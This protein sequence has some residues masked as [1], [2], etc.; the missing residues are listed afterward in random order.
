MVKAE[1]IV[2][3]YGLIDN[4]SVI[5]LYIDNI[6][7]ASQ[8]CYVL[9]KTLPIRVDL[10]IGPVPKDIPDTYIPLKITPPSETD[11]I[12]DL[13]NRTRRWYPA[14]REVA[15][16]YNNKYGPGTEEIK[17]SLQLDSPR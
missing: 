2:F 11:L 4:P 15:L 3:G 8:I 7:A 14:A 5:K 6:Y 13:P 17:A 9:G 12:K 10:W 1:D 16:A